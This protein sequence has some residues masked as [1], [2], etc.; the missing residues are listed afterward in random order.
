[1]AKKKTAYSSDV[2]TAILGIAA[3]A[4]FSTLIFVAVVYT[5]HYGSL[6]DA[7]KVTQ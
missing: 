6:M 2:Y 1:M 4:V 3:M 5:S 7:F